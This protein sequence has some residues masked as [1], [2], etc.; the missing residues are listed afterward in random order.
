LFKSHLDK[1]IMK[2]SYIYCMAVLSVVAFVSASEENFS[3]FARIGKFFS[4][5]DN[6]KDT[7]AAGVKMDAVAV[8]THLNEAENFIGAGNYS[9][10]VDTLLTI[11]ENSSAEN[12]KANALLGT[13]FLAIDRPDLAES[14]LYTAV[15]VSNY[16]DV[17]SI[18]NLAESL[19]LNGDA[20]LAIEVLERSIKKQEGPSTGMLEFVM[21]ESYAS[22]EDYTT[23]ADWFLAS[24]LLNPEHEEAWLRASTLQFPP[25]HQNYDMAESV[26]T[27]AMKAIPTSS[28]FAFSIGKHNLKS[29]FY[30]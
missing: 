20:N 14:F 13:C 11:L 15:R 23:A 3:F 16:T 7:Q 6:K 2:V 19:R 10:A 26:L 8:K 27:R 18:S 28:E 9:K 22:K 30:C 12:Q 4:R 25:A 17:A 24:A 21:G 29:T 1:D 5:K